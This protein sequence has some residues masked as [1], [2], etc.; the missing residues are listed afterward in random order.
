[1]FQPD[2]L[3][4]IRLSLWVGL[5][6]VLLGL[7][8]AVPVG[9][10]LARR[11]FPGKALLSTLVLAPIVVPP[12]VTGLALLR[13]FGR[14]SALGPVL[15]WFGVEVSFS[16]AGAVL[17]ALIV[18]LP[19]FVLSARGAFE[20]VDPAYEEVAHTMGLRPWQTF[21]RVTL[22][23]A[24]P[25]IGAGAVLGFARALGEFG[26]TTVISG[27][28]EGKTRTIALALYTLLD[29]PGGDRSMN[30]LL[31]ASLGLSFVALLG[32]EALTRWQKRRLET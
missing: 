18:G 20:A 9:W 28:M 19:F 31:G 22:P 8:I 6:C 23:L 11:T 12:V 1:V 14:S 17:A 29:A 10:L 27:N 24:L 30:V 5:W 3:S 25:G 16:L 13:F 7:P 4:A 32:Y 26:A 2:P 21:V 15:G